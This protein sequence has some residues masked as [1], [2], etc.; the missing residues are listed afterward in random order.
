MPE[1][2][3]ALLVTVGVTLVVLWIIVR[4]VARRRS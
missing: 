4:L 1:L 3:W 2:T